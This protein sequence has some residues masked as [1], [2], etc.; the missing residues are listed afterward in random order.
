MTKQDDAMVEKAIRA[1]NNTEKDWNLYRTEYDLEDIKEQV[2][3]EAIAEARK[4]FEKDK[5]DRLSRIYK[6]DIE[7]TRN[8][9]L[10]EAIR[11]LDKMDI[12]NCIPEIRTLQDAINILKKM[13]E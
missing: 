1:A 2:A 8:A 3:K 5:I 9:T 7:E 13:K 6:C 4:E 10:D 12:D 11:K